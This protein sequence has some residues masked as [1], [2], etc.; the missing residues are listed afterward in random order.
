MDVSRKNTDVSRVVFHPL[1]RRLLKYCFVPAT[2]AYSSKGFLHRPLTVPTRQAVRAINQS[3]FN[4]MS[5][6]VITDYF[7]NVNET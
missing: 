6:V 5:M 7:A 3:I 2:S 4:M 1:K